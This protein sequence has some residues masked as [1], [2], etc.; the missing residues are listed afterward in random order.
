MPLF[1]LT[2]TMPTPNVSASLNMPK[3]FMDAVETVPKEMKADRHQNMR[4]YLD[5]KSLSEGEKYGLIHNWE[6]LY[7]HCGIDN[8]E[9]RNDGVRLNDGIFNYMLISYCDTSSRTS[10]DPGYRKRLYHLSQ[11]DPFVREQML[12]SAQISAALWAGNCVDP[13]PISMDLLKKL[14]IGWVMVKPRAR[15]V[16]NRAKEV[17]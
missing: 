12:Q 4:I 14:N 2:V 6:R 7:D 17:K 5:T 16:V 13:D 11:D 15:E 10:S 3:S 8:M 9:N 1:G